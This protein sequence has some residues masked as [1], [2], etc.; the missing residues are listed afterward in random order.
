MAT[1]C[2]RITKSSASATIPH[3]KN[4]YE[5]DAKRSAAGASHHIESTQAGASG[6]VIATPKHCDRVWEIDIPS[7][8]QE[9]ICRDGTEPHIRTDISGTSVPILSWVDLPRIC[10]PLS[11]TPSHFR[12]Y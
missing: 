5:V 1:H 10:E 6:G 8:L 9:K 7:W 2:I 3:R 12:V 4:A 11:W